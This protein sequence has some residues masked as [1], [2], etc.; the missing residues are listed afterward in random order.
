[1]I[2]GPK[3]AI[4]GGAIFLG[5]IVLLPLAG[6]GGHGLKK[7]HGAVTYR[8]QPLQKGLITFFPAD[9]DGPTAAAPIINGQYS[10]PVALGRKQVRIE[11]FRVI[12]KRPASPRHPDGQ[13]VDNE[14]QIVPERYN[15]KSELFREISADTSIYEFH[16]DDPQGA[17]P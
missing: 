15:A 5:A 14:A 1:M 7:I 8:G 3:L 2:P 12:G 16:L 11:G 6:C 17:S 13:M 9:G 10:L 4:L